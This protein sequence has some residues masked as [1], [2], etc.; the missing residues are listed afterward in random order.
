MKPV[1]RPPGPREFTGRHMLIIMVAFFGVIVAV[2]FTMAWLAGRSWTGLVVKN[3]YVASQ[4]F[5]EKLRMAREQ[6]TRGWRTNL[7]YKK[8]VFRFRLADRKS[9]PLDVASL[10]LSVGRPATEAEDRIIALRQVEQG[11]YVAERRLAPGLWD[12]VIAGGPSGQ[13]YRY[14]KRLTIG[15]DGRAK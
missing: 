3:S 10:V 4:D 1:A 9:Q 5:N 8:G 15:A 12:I 7:T 6:N 14:E 2:N 11:T 13:P